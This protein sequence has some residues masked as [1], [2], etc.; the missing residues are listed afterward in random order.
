MEKAKKI[1]QIA[2]QYEKPSQ[3]LFT[4]GKG[5]NATSASMSYNS[6]V[7]THLKIAWKDNTVLDDNGWI[8]DAFDLNGWDYMPPTWTSASS[9][10][11]AEYVLFIWAKNH[12]TD[13]DG[14]AVINPQTEN[15]NTL[16]TQGYANINAFVTNSY[17][18]LATEITSG[19]FEVKLTAQTASAISIDVRNASNQVTSSL[20]SQ[21]IDTLLPFS[22]SVSNNS[23]TTFP[24]ILT[25]GAVE[26]DIGTLSWT[27][28]AY[29]ASLTENVNFATLNNVLYV[30]N[31][32]DDLLKYDGDSTYKAGLPNANKDH[33]TITPTV[34]SG[35]EATAN[36]HLHNVKPGQVETFTIDTT[37]EA[38]YAALPTEKKYTFQFD[39]VS[40]FKRKSGDATG[41]YGSYSGSISLTSAGS[42]LGNLSG[43]GLEIEVVTDSSG[44]IKNYY[45]VNKGTG[46]KGLD[47]NNNPQDRIK[48]T[49]EMFTGDNADQS[50]VCGIV[51]ITAVSTQLRDKT[52]EYKFAYEYTDYKGNVISSQPTEAVKVVVPSERKVVITMSSTLSDLTTY[53]TAG[54]F[55]AA[56]QTAN[57]V[58]F[59]S[60]LTNSN[61]PI[62][63]L[64]NQ[65]R[66]RLLIYRSKGY[67]PTEG[68]VVGQY[69]HIGDVAY[70]TTIF[71]DVYHDEQNDPEAATQYDTVLNPF[72][73]F[74]DPIKRK[75]PPPKGMYL[76][77]FKN[78][79]VV[80]GQKDNV[81]NV[82]YSLPKNFTTGEIGS[83]YFPNDDN[84]VI[85][86]S[87]FGSKITA[88]SGLKDLMF[89]FHK[90]SIFTVSGNINQLELPTVE[91]L[92]KEGGVG[93]SSQ[94]SV[95]EFKGGLS[96]V[97]D[98]GVYSV[99]NQG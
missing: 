83:E 62:E 93:C 18:S 85:V 61:A 17:P 49:K 53:E 91:L 70:G 1:F 66:L 88:I 46:Y 27:S 72:L 45:V 16:I 81:N 22:T 95:E 80:S 29:E 63:K 58:S 79:L 94:A 51:D 13:S 73:A 35:S 4:N 41:S 74:V 99:S 56:W 36:R 12:T 26:D 76:T 38:N 39:S 28:A 34:L 54:T 69:Y 15:L 11:F 7:H 89:V 5:S 92:T 30:S 43:T 8:Y 33:F 67:N 68:E 31:G 87:P 2:G 50:V 71:T 47:A 44:G 19:S 9:W 23:S 84:S 42:D 6:S 64:T 65:K 57:G 20:L 60:S 37:A 40:T 98:T 32:I 77:T 82:S 90:D 21:S 75:D 25:T 97:S 3:I 14:N 24:T 59:P 86:E 10:S 55:N 52:Y 78:C 96:F 48:V